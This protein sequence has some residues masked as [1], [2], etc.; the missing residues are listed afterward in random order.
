[1]GLWDLE[2]RFHD[3]VGEPASGAAVT[4]NFDQARE[5]IEAI[6]T[7]VAVLLAGA[8]TP[9]TIAGATLNKP[10]VVSVSKAA[11]VAFILQGTGGAMA[12]KILIG[13]VEVG[14]Y[15]TSATVITLGAYDLAKGETWEIHPE[16]GVLTGANVVTRVY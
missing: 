4:E 1:M 12:G 16:A 15:N 3:G 6:E 14:G 8:T 10:E 9:W 5:K 2:H 7:A 11:Q 13:G